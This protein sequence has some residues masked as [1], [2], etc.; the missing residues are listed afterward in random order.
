MNSLFLKPNRLALLVRF[1]SDKSQ[2]KSETKYESFL[3]EKNEMENFMERCMLTAGSKPHHAKSLASCL[4]AADYRGH[5]SHGLNRL[6]KYFM[7]EKYSIDH[8]HKTIIE[9]H[10]LIRHVC[11]RREGRHDELGRRAENC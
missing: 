8:K 11:E 5:F 4:I 7:L 6:G 10:F 1:Q 2:L 9:P 3:I